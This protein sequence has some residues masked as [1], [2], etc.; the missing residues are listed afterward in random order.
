MTYHSQIVREKTTPYL[1]IAG[2]PI[3]WDIIRYSYNL[4]F[5]I[6]RRHGAK[7][8]LPTES[9]FRAIAEFDDDTNFIFRQQAVC[10]AVRTMNS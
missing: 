4:P 5:E 8:I 3:A 6:S 1:T 2:L 10:N 9:P 7:F